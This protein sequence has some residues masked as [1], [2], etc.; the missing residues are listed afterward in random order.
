MK[1]KVQVTIEGKTFSLAGEESEIYIKQ[2][3]NYINDKFSEIRKR[4]EAKGVSSNMISVLTAINIADDYFKEMEKNVVL[5]ELNEQLKLS[6]N[7]SLSEEQIKNLEDNVKSLQS[8]ND[9]LRVLK[10]N[11]EKEIIGV[12]AEKSALER[13]LE[14]LRT[15]KSN[16]LGNIE[17]LKAEKSK[18]FKDIETLKNE[19]ENYKKELSKSNDINSSL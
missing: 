8:E 15:E 14:K 13:E 1:N 18:S 11:L 3:A 12:K 5:M 9:D 10:E 2:V 6:Q 19:N 4:E 17:V 16:L 7:L